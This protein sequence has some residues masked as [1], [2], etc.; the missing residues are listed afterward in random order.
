MAKGLRTDGY[1]PKQQI[2]ERSVNTYRPKQ[3]SC[4]M[5]IDTYFPNQLVW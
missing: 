5:S 4:E 2:G 1:H 3:Q